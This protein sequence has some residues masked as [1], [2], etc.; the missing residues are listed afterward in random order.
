MVCRLGFGWSDG[1]REYLGVWAI[2]RVEEVRIWGGH[3]LPFS[4]F[5][6]ELAGVFATVC[7]HASSMG[8]LA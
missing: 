3:V 4:T 8:M 6:L 5:V 2:A 7:G 1:G